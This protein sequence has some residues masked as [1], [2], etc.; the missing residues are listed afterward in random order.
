MFI[1]LYGLTCASL[2][3]TLSVLFELNRIEKEEQH[4]HINRPE[5]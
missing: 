5:P 1:I 4:E 3:W 2:G